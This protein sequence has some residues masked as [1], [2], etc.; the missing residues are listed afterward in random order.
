MLT[1]EEVVA[2]L[3]SVDDH[4]VA[5]ILATGGSSE[6]FA[7][8]RAWVANDEVPMNTGAPLASGRITQFVELLEAADDSLGER[9]TSVARL[10]ARDQP[11]RLIH[12]WR[13]NRIMVLL[14]VSYVRHGSGN[15]GSSLYPAGFQ[16][17]TATERHT[18]EHTR[19]YTN[20]PAR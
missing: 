7:A 13:C 14:Q 16:Q 8:A 20:R 17:A 12:H 10:S 2:A 4:L 11:E 3:G 19:S 9:G 6:E 15:H 5:E 1:R 18:V